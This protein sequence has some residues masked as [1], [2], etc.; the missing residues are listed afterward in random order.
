MSKFIDSS[1]LVLLK[2][3]AQLFFHST[4]AGAT[5]IPEQ[6]ASGI[7]IKTNDKFFLLTCKHVFENI[8]GNDVI[9]FIHSGKIVRLTSKIE[10]VSTN[11]N[12]DLAVI[13][14][15][16]LQAKNIEEQYS[17]LHYKNIEF[18]HDFNNSKMYMLLGFI[19]KQ[20]LLENK[21]FKAM[22]FGYLTTIKNIKKIGEI[23]F[24]Y[25]ENITLG[26]NRRKQSFIDSSS[27]NFG[28]KDLKG[29]SG[30]GIWFCKQH[31]NVPNL[32]DC[33]LVGLM[34]EERIERGFIIGSKI[35]LIQET[36][37]KTFGAKLN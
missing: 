13:E 14:L 21:S 16:P 2:S 29:L 7:F 9:I 32:L 1:S 28:P 25:L 23:G 35:S 26:Y 34:I 33:S 3:T 11:E 15:N 12:I 36:L 6:I 5:N 30:G 31:P 27:I 19:N 20:T 17:F 37:I 18:Y 4:K 10:F 24:N 22:P 8:K